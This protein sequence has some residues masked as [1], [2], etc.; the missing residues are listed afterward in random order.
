MSERPR[1]TR[2]HAVLID[3]AFDTLTGRFPTFRRMEPALMAEGISRIEARAEVI[4]E[5]LS[6]LDEIRRRV[7]KLKM[8]IEDGKAWPNK[9]I[10]AE[11]GYSPGSVSRIVTSSLS[12]LDRLYSSPEWKEV[13]DD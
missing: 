8:G 10:G 12:S 1:I 2:E 6:P 4:D 3:R 11:V 13:R 7:V 5:I 9:A